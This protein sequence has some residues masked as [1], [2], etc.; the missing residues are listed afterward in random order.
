MGVLPAGS[1]QSLVLVVTCPKVIHQEYGPRMTMPFD[2]GMP[3]T[4]YGDPGTSNA[5][6]FL[7][8]RAS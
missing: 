2:K 4:I 1:S 3:V 5:G 7:T 8:I 6:T